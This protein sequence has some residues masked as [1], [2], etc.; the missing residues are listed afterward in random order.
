MGKYL[1]KTEQ[2]RLHFME[3]FKSL[4]THAPISNISIG[5]L[6]KKAGY[7]RTTFYEYFSD[8]YDILEQFEQDTI[9]EFLEIMNDYIVFEQ[10]IDELELML[11]HGFPQAYLAC[12]KNM[13]LLLG[14]NGDPAFPGKMFLGLSD[15]FTPM[16]NRHPKEYRHLMKYGFYAL[17]SAL[18]SW[19]EDGRPIPLEKMM[20]IYLAS[21]RRG[22][23][24]FKECGANVRRTAPSGID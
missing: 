14:K 5:A 12:E 18:Y 21:I 9:T 17:L 10:K 13:A 24:M 11:V 23:Q 19:N 3:A 1:H 16:L 6:C 22:H 8:I 2:T 4:Y 7:S 15:R 20:E